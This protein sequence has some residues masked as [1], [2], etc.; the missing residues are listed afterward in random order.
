MKFNKRRRAPIC[1]HRIH[2]NYS[3]GCW[4]LFFSVLTVA[5]SSFPS[6]SGHAT[7][8]TSSLSRTCT[9]KSAIVVGAGPAGLA[10]ALM[11]A[12]NHNYQVTILES[13]SKSKE[14][15]LTFD[16]SRA[17]LYNINGRGQVFT[18][19]F[20]QLQRELETQG[21]GIRQFARLTVPADPSEIFDANQPWSR[22]L[23]Q[24]VLDKMGILYWIPRYLFLKVLLEQVE[25]CGDQITVC[26]GHE[27]QGIRPDNGLIQVE[28]TNYSD[29][30]NEASPAPKVLLANLVVGAEGPR[31]KIRQILEDPTSANL[32]HGWKNYHPTKFRLRKWKSP[33]VGLRLKTLQFEANFQIPV[34][35]GTFVDTESTYTYAFPSLNQ[36]S[37]NALSLTLLP[38]RDPT[39]KR[40]V[41]V[42]TAPSHDLWQL[43]TG[44]ELKAWMTQSFPRLFATTGDESMNNT[45]VTDE[46][47]DRFAKSEGSRFPHCQYCAGLAIASLPDPDKSS[48]VS[49]IA[50]IGDTIHAFP[51]DMGQGVNM[52]LGD[53]AV[54]DDCLAESSTKTE[55]NEVCLN[56]ALTEYQRRREAETKAVVRLCRFAAPFQYGQQ[57][58]SRLLRLRK[59]FWVANIGLRTILHK[60]TQGLLPNPGIMAMMDPKL[61]FATIMRRSDRLTIA[62]WT[63]LIV[64]LVKLSSLPKR[65]TALLQYF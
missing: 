7:S 4:L 53:V 54:L 6:V 46:E 15:H 58:Q 47:W 49:G 30:N 50:L 28:T 35:D 9:S 17:Y 39:A 2:Q 61:P 65:M 48:P 25:A 20:P 10:A 18:N 40:P 27:C 5:A 23:P 57:N 37:K 21:V 1:P 19:R 29:M 26:F 24:S 11:L 64:L 8:S 44:P 59:F 32:F 36:T 45:L 41:A 13:S 51:P 43:R 42:A 31:S 22:G 16:P 14:E 38:I 12:Q 60:V 34:G 52:A 63:L 55:N 3:T 56:T 62:L 33:S